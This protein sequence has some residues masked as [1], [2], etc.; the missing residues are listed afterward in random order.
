MKRPPIRILD[1]KGSPEEIGHQHGTT[2][3]DEIKIYT[4]ERIH[5]ASGQ[6]WAG[7][8]INESEILEIAESC[9]PAH[10]KHSPELYAEMCAMAEGAGITPAEAVIVGGFT[11]FVDTVRNTF[12]GTYPSEVI[13]DDCTAF[14]VPDSKANGQGL[15]GQTWDMHDTAT[16]HVVLMRIQPEN[17]SPSALIFSTVGCLGQI[18]MNSHG[19]CV[20]INNLVTTDGCP[21]VMWPSVVRAALTTSSAD[22]ALNEILT[23]DLAG[24]HSF[25]IF[26]S[27]GNGHMIEAMPTARPYKT[28][29]QEPLVHTNHV[30]WDQAK[31]VEA[32]RDLNIKANSEHRLSRATELLAK[33]NLS[34]EDLIEVTRDPEAICRTSKDPYHI[35]S[36]GAAIMCPQT[37]DFWAVWGVPNLN[38]YVHVPFHE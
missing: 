22:E 9:L 13:E 15:Y 35:E 27:T 14:I 23:A 24:A 38:E 25:L 33:E 37:L 8:E 19:V 3:A 20:G 29:E 28:L 7:Q 2:Y 31:S 5:L 4:R 11:D 17:G 6:F 36:S 26:D 32:L 16:D 34:V 1:L 21:G 18:G 10:E 12:G 30:L